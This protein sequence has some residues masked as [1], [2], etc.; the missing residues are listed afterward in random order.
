MLNAVGG[1]SLP[2]SG[3]GYYHPEPYKTSVCELFAASPKAENIVAES[4][5]MERP[6]DH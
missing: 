5:A 4:K 3:E 6:S 2:S 1:Y